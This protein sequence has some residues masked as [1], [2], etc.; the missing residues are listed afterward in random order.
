M[1]L[2]SGV[3]SVPVMGGVPSVLRR[4]A[5]RTGPVIAQFRTADNAIP[6]TKWLNVLVT[7]ATER[8]P[9]INGIGCGPEC[10]FASVPQFGVTER[11]KTH[12]LRWRP[13]QHGMSLYR[14]EPAGV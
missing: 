14:D 12:L 3:A 7:S 8:Y 11:Y 10:G 4:S 5:L 6:A 9:Y 1:S 13:L 2:V